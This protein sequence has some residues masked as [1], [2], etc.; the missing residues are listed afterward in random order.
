M[1][2][3]SS[4]GAEMVDASYSDAV[5]VTPSDT[6]SPATR[7]RQ[8]R[9]IW[10]DAGGTVTVVT[11]AA[12][13]RADQAGGGPFGQITAL[14]IT[15]P[16][17][18]YDTATVAFSGGGGSGAAATATVTAGAISAL[19]ITNPGEGYTSAP[20]VTITH[21][22][23]GSG[24]TAQ[25]VVGEAAVEFTLLPGVPLPLHVAYVLATGTAATGLKV[26]K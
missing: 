20:T 16:G 21:G 8:V 18:L 1:G 14:E 23:A 15:A 12:A 17:T 9:A 10:S 19:T 6:I 26:L 4:T 5:A 11:D 24:A 2:L 22:S 7:L 3:Q 13:G 25:A